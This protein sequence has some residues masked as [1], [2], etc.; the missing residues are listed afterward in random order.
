MTP[1]NCESSRRNDVHCGDQ[2]PDTIQGNVSNKKTWCDKVLDLCTVCVGE[3]AL[4]LTLYPS[5]SGS[6][7]FSP[8][9][10]SKHAMPRLGWVPLVAS[11]LI[12][13]DG[14]Y[15]I[16]NLVEPGERHHLGQHPATRN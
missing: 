1:A 11:L 9:S 7:T 2:R 16:E 5:R 15:L 3:M 12:K 14:T 4:T 6:H 13:V 8:L 10:S